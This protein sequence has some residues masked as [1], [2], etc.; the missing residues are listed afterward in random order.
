MLLHILVIFQIYIKCHHGRYLEERRTGGEDFELQPDTPS[1][2]SLPLDS[3]SSW[4]TLLELNRSLPKPRRKGTI[5][6][7]Y[8]RQK[9]IGQLEAAMH[10]NQHQYQGYLPP[11]EVV[12][13]ALAYSTVFYLGVDQGGI[14]GAI[15]W[16][17][18][19]DIKMG[20]VNID[21][22]VQALRDNVK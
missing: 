11:K 9:N 1:E 10:Q 21:K 16:A 8:L 20:M 5:V 12:Q 7:I 18:S 19:Q 3:D 22:F 15:N 4:L 13:L 17:R 2:E 14:K 6:D